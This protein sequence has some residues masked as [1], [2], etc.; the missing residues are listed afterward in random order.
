MGDKEKASQR[1]T[2]ISVQPNMVQI[3]I[4]LTLKP[5]SINLVQGKE[6]PK[7]KGNLKKGRV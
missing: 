6:V 1:L 3:R 7:K 5:I 4:K 2:L